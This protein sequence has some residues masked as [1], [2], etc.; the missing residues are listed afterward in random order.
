MQVDL[1]QL[2]NEA[3]SGNKDAEKQLL[4][5]LSVRFR[6]IAYH[7][8][9]DKE[10][11]EDVAQEALIS[12]LK[13]YRDLKLRSS[14]AAW[15]HTIVHRQA[16]QFIEKRKKQIEGAK[17]LKDREVYVPEQG[18]IKSLES[19]ILQCL[20]KIS[21]NNRSFARI[22]NLK[23]LG[24]KFEEICEKLDMNRNQAYVALHR[25]RLALASCLKLGDDEV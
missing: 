9:K 16:L 12:V 21:K 15:V 2:F 11:A 4:S 23:H 18:S 6:L 8:L 13:N 7:I 3:K 25:A 20:Q 14:F 1:N 24:F 19:E 17:K 10:D 5:I 22:L